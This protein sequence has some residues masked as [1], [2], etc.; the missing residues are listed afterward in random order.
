MR[1]RFFFNLPTAHRPPP[2]TMPLP[3]PTLATLVALGVIHAGCKASERTH[4]DLGLSLAACVTRGD[5]GRALT[6]QLVHLD[7]THFLLNAFAL[8]SVGAA[9]QAAVGG[10]AAQYAVATAELLALTGALTL[11]G[12]AGLARLPILVERARPGTPAPAWTA[13]VA[14]RAARTSIVGYSG[15]I[16]G[17]FAIAALA[18]GGRVP[19][20][21][22]GWSAPAIWGPILSLAACAVIIPHSSALGHASGLVAGVAVWAV[23]LAWLTPGLVFTLACWGVAAAL[24]GRHQ[25]AKSAAEGSG[26]DVEAGGGGGQRAG[27]L[28]AASA[29]ARAA[30]AAAAMARA[31]AAGGGG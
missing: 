19:L 4:D 31:V 24:F 17:W 21:V 7:T 10:G 20:P 22:G 29:E 2:T 13:A 5:L 25:A 15:V 14:D 6:A 8:A 23:G 3:A 18:S 27:L 9:G 12:L 30:A 16:F 28:D 26:L 1:A 11:A